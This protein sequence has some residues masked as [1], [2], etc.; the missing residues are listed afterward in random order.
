LRPHFEPIGRSGSAERRSQARRSRALCRAGA[1]RV[2]IRLSDAPKRRSSSQS[3]AL[4]RLVAGR[5]RPQLRLREGFLLGRSTL[6]RAPAREHAHRPNA[7]QNSHAGQR[8]A[9]K[10]WSTSIPAA[11]AAYKSSAT[12]RSAIPVP[13]APKKTGS[14]SPTHGAGPLPTTWRPTCRRRC[15]CHRTILSPPN[16]QCHATGNAAEV[17]RGGVAL[18]SEF[19]HKP[20]QQPAQDFPPMSAPWKSM[21]TSEIREG[22]PGGSIK[23]LVAV[24]RATVT[25]VSRR[26]GC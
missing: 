7:A 3:A 5:H 24:R 16:Q 10:W 14:F 26:V 11:G 9:A 1:I 15:R 23:P 18:I 19:I 12:G 22:T 13:A 25:V 21:T 20:R 6:C 17:E 8:R 2:S 4:H